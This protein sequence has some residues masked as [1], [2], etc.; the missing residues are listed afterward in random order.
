MEG[1][2]SLNKSCTKD[3][4]N[5][6]MCHVPDFHADKIATKMQIFQWHGT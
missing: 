6:R 3:D 5:D 4:N 1:C 2:T